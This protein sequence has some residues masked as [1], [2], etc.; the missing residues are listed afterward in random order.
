MGHTV[1][2]K[3]MKGNAYSKIKLVLAIPLSLYLTKLYNIKQTKNTNVCAPCL[4]G[5]C[6]V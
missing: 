1:Y 2:I 6:P 3:F 5:L 4:Y